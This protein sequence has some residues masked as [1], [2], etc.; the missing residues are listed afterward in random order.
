MQLHIF[1][2]IWFHE[3]LF[4]I[5]SPMIRDWQWQR[6]L[7]EQGK[8]SDNWTAPNW[9]YKQISKFRKGCINVAFNWTNK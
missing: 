5:Q 6:V 7:N 9:I 8:L 4:N 2:G 1:S 3:N